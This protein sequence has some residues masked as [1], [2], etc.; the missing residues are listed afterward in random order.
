MVAAPVTGYGNRLTAHGSDKL[1]DM[2]R[3]PRPG[4]GM[5][6]CS[7]GTSSAM[8]DRFS[9]RGDFQSAL[10]AVANRAQ[11]TILPHKAN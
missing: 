8:W 4:N 7:G 2:R 10:G 6:G 9:M 5:Y 1:L 3:Q 11:D